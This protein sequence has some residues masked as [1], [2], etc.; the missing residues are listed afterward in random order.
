VRSS[1]TEGSQTDVFVFNDGVAYLI[2]Q[3]GQW[4][5]ELVVALNLRTGVRIDLPAFPG[6][7]FFYGAQRG[8]LADRK[9][10][11]LFMA[12]GLSASDISWFSYNLANN[13]V[14]TSGDSPYHGDFALGAEFYLSGNQD[15][16]FTSA[17]TYFN[18][19]TLRYARTLS[20]GYILHMTHS[21]T[22]DEALVLQPGVG[23][24]YPYPRIY[25]P[26]YRRFSGAL[27]YEDA[28]IPLTT[29]NGGQSY[30]LKIFHSANDDHVI[31]AQT[32]S[33][34]DLAPG[35]QYHLIVR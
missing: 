22:A 20:T 26:Y 28:N 19:E 1:A 9:N 5:D 7:A 21:S 18:A 29:V 25:Q 8:A 13:H 31:L 16:L 4:V 34:A 27:F 12:Y 6:F 17:G 33:D 2:G 3:R 24:S 32:G 14:L 15:L 10:R 11:V 30:G 23:S 35:V